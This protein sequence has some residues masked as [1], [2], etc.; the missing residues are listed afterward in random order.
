MKRSAIL[1]WGIA[2]LQTCGIVRCQTEEL[3]STTTIRQQQPVEIEVNLVEE[4]SPYGHQ[5]LR[6]RNEQER[7]DPEY[8]DWC[9]RSPSE[10]SLGVVIS[11]Y[12]TSTCM[13]LYQDGLDNKIPGN[14]CKPIRIA[15]NEPCGCEPL[16][17]NDN[18][19]ARALSNAVRSFSSFEQGSPVTTLSDE[20]K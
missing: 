19:R 13:G 6:G 15:L 11:N 12:G 20:D 17:E 4:I 8:C 18:N 1:C 5:Q 14:F 10:A 16:P 9:G 2:F 3:S 7:T